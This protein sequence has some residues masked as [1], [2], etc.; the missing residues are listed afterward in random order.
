MTSL[1]VEA[2]P[3]T[4]LPTLLD[5]VLLDLAPVVLEPRGD[6]V[7]AAKAFLDHASY[8]D[9]HPATNLGAP[10]TAGGDELAAVAALAQEAGVLAVVVDG[11]AVHDQGA[12]DVQELRSRCSAPS[13]RSASSRRADSPSP[14][15]RGSSSFATPPPTT[16]PDDREAASR[17]PAWARVLKLP[18]VKGV[19]QRQ[20]VVTSRAMIASTT[21]T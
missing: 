3:D 19:D 10:E 15:L 1:W 2:A 11:T 12:S 16:V 18:G 17:P 6:A 4:D 21:P 14:T 5:N 20:H 8:V 7:A 9:L 13:P